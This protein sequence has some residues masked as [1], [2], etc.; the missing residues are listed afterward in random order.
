MQ[1]P[2]LNKEKTSIW[3]SEI[4]FFALKPFITQPSIN[5]LHG[6]CFLVQQVG[7]ESHIY[8]FKYNV[9][10]ICLFTPTYYGFN[11]PFGKYLWANRKKK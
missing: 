2:P 1:G 10:I 5:L 9:R 8:E 11:L 4:S 7:C 6:I 3:K